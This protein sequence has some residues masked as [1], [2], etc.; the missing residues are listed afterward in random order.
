MKKTKT[1]TQQTNKVN[2]KKN[3]KKIIFITVNI[4]V[5]AILL[6][7]IVFN[8]ILSIKSAVNPDKLPTVFG[9]APTVV[10]T[11]SM[12]PTIYA[13]DLIFV[14][15]VAIDSLEENDIICFKSNDSFI[16]HRLERIEEIDGV[17]RFYTKGDANNLGDDGF[18]LAEQIQ[19]E[20]SWKIAG[21]GGLVLFLQSPY[22]ILL[23]IILLVLLYLTAELL[24]EYVGKIRENKK[25]KAELEALKR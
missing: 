25:L 5:W 1:K 18:I 17:K 22:G 20:Y 7:I 21:L 19:G 10:M 13:K 23:V 14:K 15:N 11:G 12:E 24:I 2:K 4:T 8:T 9:V 3:V 6:P 16:V